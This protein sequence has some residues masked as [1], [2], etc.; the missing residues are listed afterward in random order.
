[1]QTNA[2]TDKGLYVRLSELNLDTI[3]EKWFPDI[4]V[5]DDLI[6]EIMCEPLEDNSVCIIGKF[7]YGNDFEG[8]VLSLLD[9]DLILELSA[10]ADDWVIMQ[11]PRPANLFHAAYESENAL[12]AE[13]IE[14]YS[15]YIL[16]PKTFDFRNRLVYLRGTSWC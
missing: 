10:I 16:N 9:P 6:D 5:N 13:M 4:N 11:L 14:L 12:L 8:D 7:C 15:P 3:R 2:I 1:M